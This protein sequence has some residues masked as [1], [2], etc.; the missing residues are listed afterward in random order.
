M[1]KALTTVEVEMIE[2]Q[3]Q[4]ADDYIA[5]ELPTLP[6]GFGTVGIA[7]QEL[8]ADGKLLDAQELLVCKATFSM[9]P[10]IF[11]GTGVSQFAP[12]SVEAAARLIGRNVGPMHMRLVYRKD[13][14]T[15]KALASQEMEAAESGAAASGL[16]GAEEVAPKTMPEEGAS[17]GRVRLPTEKKP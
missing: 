7:K 3:G 14:L 8:K 13:G 11:S 6:G 10:R 9:D 17:V 16:D 5:V 15:P 2:A 12:Q 4:N 1:I